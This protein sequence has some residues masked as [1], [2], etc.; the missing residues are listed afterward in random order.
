MKTLNVAFVGCGNMSHPHAK[1]FLAIPEAKVVALCD[2][3]A[4][5]MGGV[6]KK[7]F[8]DAAQFTSYDGLLEASKKL[9]LDGVVIITPHT[10][11]HGQI[12]SALEAGLHVLTEKPMVTSSQHAY[13]LWKTVKKT[14]KILAISFQST[15]TREFAFIAAERGAGRLGKIQLISGL[16]NQAWLGVTTNTW[17]QN[18]ELSGGGQ[19]YDSGAHMLNAFIWLINEPV[20]EVACFYDR[21]GTP[22]DI[23]GVAII[24]FA[25]GVLGSVCIGGNCPASAGDIQIHTD[26]MTIRTDTSGSKVE[27]HADAGRFYPLVAADD[28]PAAGTPQ[29]NFVNAILH[30][31][32]LRT[33]VRYGVLLSA[34]MDGLYESARAKKPVRVE[35]VPAD[36]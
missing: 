3:D 29:L 8:P 31:E 34:L 5:K 27:M 22:V 2:I 12:K 26:K 24:K 14:G 21:C 11:H 1:N 23:N 17:R 6:G 9:A 16:L 36:I 30:G 15:Y 33:P 7:Y 32:K 4:A 13:D 19:M 20:V 28:R 25:S 10:L 18:P 35:P